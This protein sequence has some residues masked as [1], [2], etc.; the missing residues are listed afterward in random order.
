MEARSL[1]NKLEKAIE[2]M[3]GRIGRSF[4]DQFCD[5]ME[6]A[7]GDRFVGSVTSALS[8]PRQRSRR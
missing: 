8:C 7:L 2:D 4:S 3:D 5:F 6:M 1:D